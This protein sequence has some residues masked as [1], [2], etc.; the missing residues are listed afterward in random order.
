MLSSCF[1]QVEEE[2]WITSLRCVSDI[3]GGEKTVALHQEFLI[4]S[5]HTDLQILT[6]TKVSL[7]LT[8]ALNLSLS[9]SLSLTLSLSLSLSLSLTLSLFVHLLDIVSANHF[10]PPFSYSPTL[11]LFFLS[12][13]PLL[14]H[15]HPFS[16]FLFLSSISLSIL[17]LSLSGFWS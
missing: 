6:N 3:L 16:L 5:N 1:C 10:I 4:R 15:S 17:S 13:F 14:C 11:S 2:E 9:L 7:G 12:I 8:W